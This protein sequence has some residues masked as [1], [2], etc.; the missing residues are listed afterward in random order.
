M[1]LQLTPEGP[2]IIFLS[3][4]LLQHAM[5]GL[6]INWGLAPWVLAKSEMA[7]SDSDCPAV[8]GVRDIRKV[9]RR[10]D[11]P[12]RPDSR[13]ELSAPVV[14]LV[15]G[16]CKPGK[17][18]RTVSASPLTI[19]MTVVCT[20]V[21]DPVQPGVV[22]HELLPAETVN[23][24]VTGFDTSTPFVATPAIVVG[25]QI[26]QVKKFPTFDLSESSEL[27]PSFGLSSS[28]SS[29]SSPT[30]A[31]DSSLSFSPIRV[32]EG[33]S[34]NVPSEGSLFNVS[35][36]SPEIVV[37]PTRENG[38]TQPQG[39]L[40]PTILDDFND[41]VLGDP[42]SYARIEQVPGSESPL[43]L[44]V[45]AWPLKPAFM[46][47]FVIRTVLAPRKSEMLPAETKLAAPHV[48]SEKARMA[49]SG[50]PGC[51]YRF[52][53]SG[54]LPFTDGN[55]AY[56]LQLHHPCFLELVGAPESARLLDC[57]PSCW[58]EELGKEGAM[59]AETVNKS[60]TGFD[61]STPFVATPAIVVGQQI[62]QVKKFP[63]FDL[64]ESSELLPSFG[65]S[66]SSSSSSSPT[67]AEDSSPLFSPI[68]V[69]EGHSQN[70]P[71]EG[72]LF[73]VSPLSPEIVV[74]PTR[75]NGTTQPQGVLLPTILDD[76]NDSVLGDPISYARIEQVPGS[77]SPLS[78]PVYAWPLKP[79]FMM[80][81]V[82]RTV[83]APQKSEMLPAETKLA[84]PHVTS[85]KARMAK[86][87]LPG[88]PYR[89]LE[90]GELPFTD[91]N[92]AYGLQLHHPRFL[93]LVGAPESAR[94]LDCA[95]SCWVEEL[96]KE[97][98]MVAAATLQ[99]DA[100]V[101]LSNLQILFQFAMALNRMSFSMMALG[102]ERSLFPESEVDALAPA[103]RAHRAAPYMPTMGLWHP[104][105]NPSVPKP[106]PAPSCNSCMNCK[107]CFPEDQLPP[108]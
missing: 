17:V 103:P 59:V 79:A 49:K 65:L 58:V 19:D 90:S 82:I 48:T 14:D 37:Q 52:L 98:A 9:V 92:P 101:M 71:S 55:P 93:E 35:P 68:R 21:P 70:V 46:M 104:Q 39:V 96:G 88:C 5:S 50:L 57:A 108:E 43:S 99:R 1:Q 25:Q 11:G 22:A 83:L 42:I 44:P 23:K 18:T 95:P 97:G 106:V 30:L 64:S 80:D 6:P 67:L 26:P 31:E 60:V 7:V 8:S 76:F 85:E 61:T 73:N 45:Y 28:S 89:F 20:P 38:T 78:L 75:E 102:L 63:T 27:L 107:Y 72:S 77:E 86:S 3:H 81:S 41:S 29:S 105:K 54:E 10:R 56:G 36:L 32:R 94:L 53:E 13:Q 69:R 2:W 100:G 62:P 33:H 4:N 15:T 24:S 91:G 74:Q 51:P 87:G 66:S 47:D 12:A 34:Q 84:A 16:K 40:L